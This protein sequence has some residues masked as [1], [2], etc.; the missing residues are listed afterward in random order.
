M[1]IFDNALGN[2][3]GPAFLVLYLLFI[4]VVSI[5]TYAR[6]N[7]LDTTDWD[8]PSPIPKSPNPYDIAVLRGG[9]NE[10]A[11]TLIAVLVDRRLVEIKPNTGGSVHEPYL[12]QRK[13]GVEPPR[14][15]PPIEQ[16]ALAYFHHPR[17]P[18]RV[19]ELRGIGAN[20]GG[21][22]ALI[23]ARLCDQGLMPTARML[24]RA[25]HIVLQGMF[26]ITALGAYKLSAAFHHGRHNVIFLVIMGFIGTLLQIPIGKVPRITRRGLNYLERLTTAFVT[27]RVHRDE[28]DPVMR[29]STVA[30]A[31]AIFGITAAGGLA[32]A[33]MTRAFR[34]STK[35]D[36]TSSCG[37][38]MHGCGSSTTDHSA[39]TSCGS[40]CSGGGGGS[41]CGGCGGGGGD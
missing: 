15:L 21:E 25:G 10:L 14:D 24:N 35:S 36:E 40:S 8:G 9:I 32:G 27:L 38:A 6:R 20:I 11:R 39:T 13:D 16:K 22:V 3:P 2:M 18:A 34:R 7:A 28:A 26:A 41:G 5:V 1:W 33:E 31:T 17:A 30:L 23:E 4:V 29:T 37:G 12:L 19:F